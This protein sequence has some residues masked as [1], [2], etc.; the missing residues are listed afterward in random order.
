MSIGNN[1]REKRKEKGLTQQQLAAKCQTYDSAIRRYESGRITPKLDTLQRIAAAL[2]CS[3][4]D[5]MDEEYFNSASIE[6]Q[7][8]L[9]DKASADARA[10]SD[11]A[12]DIANVAGYRWIIPNIN[13]HRIHLV[14]KTSG[15]EYAVSDEAFTA[16]VDRSADYAIYNFDVLIQSAEIVRNFTSNE[17]SQD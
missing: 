13:D 11:R 1:I 3:V 14:D 6:E 9:L 10:R 12:Y 2:D 8:A 16:A 17:K 5:L 4:F 7:R 15:I